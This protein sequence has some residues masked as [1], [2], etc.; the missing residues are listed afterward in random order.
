MLKAGDT[1]R[2]RRTRPKRAESV[3]KM[4]WGAGLLQELWTHLFA[5][6]DIGESNI[7]AAD[8]VT[9]ERGGQVITAIGDNM[10]KL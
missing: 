7:W 2:T 5:M 4:G 1:V 9:A 8:Q 10:R 3:R 6:D